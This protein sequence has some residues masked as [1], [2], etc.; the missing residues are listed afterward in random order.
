MSCDCVSRHR[1][2]YSMFSPGY[3]LSTSEDL[4]NGA[5]IERNQDQ[6]S[7]RCGLD[8]GHDSEVF[9]K[10]EA[11]AFRHLMEGQVVGHSVM[12]PLILESELSSVSLEL[13][14][15]ERPA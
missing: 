3:P 14:A 9:S 2:F 12:E 1:F 7:V 10:E 5:L 8:V 13:E 4:I 11:F 15:E 6:I